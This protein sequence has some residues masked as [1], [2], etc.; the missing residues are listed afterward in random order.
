MRR[1]YYLNYGSNL[2]DREG[3]LWAAD[4]RVSIDIGLVVA[5]S[6]VVESAPWGYDSDNPY[7]NMAVA[8]ESFCEPLEVLDIIHEIERELNGGRSHRDADGNYLDRMIDIDIMAIGSEVIDL[9]QLQVPHP[10]LMQRDFFR[11]PFAEIAPQW[12]HPVTGE[13]LI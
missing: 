3:N 9:P 10:R 5:R 12:R 7:L 11:L 6:K 4:L 8:V 1:T 13:S 2:G